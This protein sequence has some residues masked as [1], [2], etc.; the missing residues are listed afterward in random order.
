MK[1][2]KTEASRK[3]ERHIITK[4]SFELY[5]NSKYPFE[6]R[7]SKGTLSQ[8]GICPSC[9]NPI[10]LIGIS[11]EIKVSPH[12]KHTGKD[13]IGLPKWEHQR[14]IYCPYAKNSEYIAPN[15][16]DMLPDIDENIVELYD[17][18][19]EQFDRV[20]YVIENVLN[21]KCSP[22]FWRKALQLYVNNHVYCYP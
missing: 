4:D 22:F 7:T 3:A 8:Y 11:H 20:V 2:F 16:Q 19:R 21:I 6:Q 10:Q 18:V 14:Y 15:E 9:L 1:Y 17:L 12:G 5:T 13:I